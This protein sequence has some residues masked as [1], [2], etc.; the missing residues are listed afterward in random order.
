MSTPENKSSTRSRYCSLCVQSRMSQLDLFPFCENQHSRL[1]RRFNEF[2]VQFGI[3]KCSGV[4]SV[5]DRNRDKW[6]D[7][8]GRSCGGFRV[9]CRMRSYR[10]QQHVCFDVLHL[11]NDICVAA[12][13]DVLVFDAKDDADG[14][15]TGMCDACESR[16][17]ESV[18]RGCARGVC[19]YCGEG[20]AFDR[21]GCSFDERLR[22]VQFCDDF[23]RAHHN[24]VIASQSF[25]GFAVV[26]VGVCVRHDEKVCRFVCAVRE[27]GVDVNH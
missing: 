9:H 24:S 18:R 27:D 12:V 16:L 2:F 26:V 23:A 4:R 17:F 8:F 19:R 22:V 20:Y 15:S 25:D 6:F 1:L 14:V 11:G 13:V 10:H 5:V 21:D 3:V 7:E